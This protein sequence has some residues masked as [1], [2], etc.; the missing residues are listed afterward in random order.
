MESPD[1]EK[2]EAVKASFGGRSL[3]EDRFTETTVNTSNKFKG[4]IKSAVLPHFLDSQHLA[5]ARYTVDVCV[6]RTVLVLVTS[7]W[8]IYS[9]LMAE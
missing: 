8:L 1:L 3:L 5:R 9:P 7:P 2:E 6:G 4:K